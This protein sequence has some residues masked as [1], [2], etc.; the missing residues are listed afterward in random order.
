MGAEAAVAHADAE[1]GAEP[2]GHQGVVHALDGE[3]GHAPA[4]R[5]PGSGS[6][7]TCTP[8][9]AR[10]PSC[11]RVESAASCVPIMASQP[12]RSSSSMAAPKATAPITLGEPASSRSGGSVQM[13]SSRS[14]RSTAPPPARK[15]SPV[16]KT[17][18]GPDQRAGAVGGVE[19]VPAEGDEV[20]L[21]GRRTVRGQLG[22]IEQDRDARGRGPRRRSPPPA[23]TSR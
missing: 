4:C 16:A 8:S 3:G 14:T 1:L 17:L 9:M 2:G 13:T 23:A 19:L 22:R 18:P 6:P 5:R 21:G 7:S 15:G 12:M 20:G 10:R 11:S